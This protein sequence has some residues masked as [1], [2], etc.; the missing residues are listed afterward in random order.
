MAAWPTSF[1]LAPWASTTTLWLMA[2]LVAVFWNV[3]RTVWPGWTV[4][5]FV[6]YSIISPTGVIVASKAGPS[7][8]ATS[9]ATSAGGASEAVWVTAG[10]GAVSVT[11][12]AS[13]PPQAERARPKARASVGMRGV[14]MGVGWV[15]MAGGP[16]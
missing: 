13:S 6:S 9:A 10:S 4:I 2:G 15:R 8:G 16:G 14:I 7:Y 11:A 1:T 3:S 5:S 12:G